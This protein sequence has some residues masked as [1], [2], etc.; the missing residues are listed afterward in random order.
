MADFEAERRKSVILTK[1]KK[2]KIVM[3]S[4][5]E[6]SKMPKIVMDSEEEKSKMQFSNTVPPVTLA[7]YLPYHQPLGSFF[8]LPREVRNEIYSEVLVVEHPVFL[9]QDGSPRVETFAPDKPHRWLSLLFVNRQMHREASA[10]LYGLNDYYLVDATQQQVDLLGSFVQSIGS[11]NSGSLSHL[12]IN[13]PGAEIVD[14]QSGKVKLQDG[15]MQV[16]RLLRERCTNLRTIELSIHSEYSSW[17]T[18]S[19]GSNLQ[20][21]QDGLQQIDA[22]LR[23]NPSLQTI[24]VRARDDN[25]PPLVND[26]MQGFRWVILRGRAKRPRDKR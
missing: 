8:N 2:P 23:A 17:L 9:F 25:P 20:V 5:E 13:F 15:S 26:L 4:E 12:C 22:Q 1:L 21:I 24:I 19:I 16:F 10:V 3:D 14:D 7:S 6:K 11:M 18:K